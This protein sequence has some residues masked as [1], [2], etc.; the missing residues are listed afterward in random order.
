MDVAATEAP[1]RD[2]DN[3]CSTLPGKI[4]KLAIVMAVNS[5]RP[6]VADRATAGSSFCACLYRYLISCRQN[7]GDG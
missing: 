7:L 3:H 2:Y 4:R 6:L 1:S 5:S